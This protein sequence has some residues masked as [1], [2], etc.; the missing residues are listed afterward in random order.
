MWRKQK[1]GCSEEQPRKLLL[2]GSSFHVKVT[3]VVRPKDIKK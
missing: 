2:M 3:H 1:E